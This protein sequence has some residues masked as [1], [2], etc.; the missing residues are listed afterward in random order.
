MEEIKYKLPKEFGE[1]WLA[2]LRSGKYP[3]SSGY[4]KR[5]TG[6]CCLGVGCV[7]NGIEESLLFYKGYPTIGWLPDDTLIYINDGQDIHLEATLANMNDSGKTFL[8][9]ADWI[10]INVDFY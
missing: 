8:E 7:I 4:L 2:A 5:D 1:K 10:E 6:Y 9:I 3:Q